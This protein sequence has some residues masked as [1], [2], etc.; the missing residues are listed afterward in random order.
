MPFLTYY[1]FRFIGRHCYYRLSADIGDGTVETAAPENSEDAVE[2][3]LLSSRGVKLEGR[4]F[5]APP[6]VYVT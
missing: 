4:R 5:T 3:L 1:Y 6:A 2:R